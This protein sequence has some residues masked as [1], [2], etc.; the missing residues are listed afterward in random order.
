MNCIPAR[1]AGV[2]EI[3]MVTPPQ[4]DGTANPD[5]LAAAA[6]AAWTGSS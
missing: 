3:V 4:K 2:G 1:I 5:I 6:V